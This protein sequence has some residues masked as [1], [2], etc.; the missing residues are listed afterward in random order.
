MA[1]GTR[2]SSTV[3]P[4]AS[5]RGGRLGDPGPHVGVDAVAVELARRCRCAGPRR[6][7]RARRRSDGAGC[8]I[9][10]E[11]IGSWPA[12][13]SSTS[14]GVGD[15]GG[16]RADL[17]EARREGDEPVAGH[18]RRR[19]ASRRRRRTAPPAG[20]SSRRCRSRGRAAAKPAATAAALPPARAA[21]HP[22]GV[23]R[24]AGRAE[25]RVLGRRAHG[26]L[27][28]VRLA[29]DDGAGGAQ[30]LDDGGVVRRPPAV[31]DLRRAG[32]RDAAGAEVVLEGDGHAGQRAGVVAGGDPRGRSRRPRPGPRRPARG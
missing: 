8:G 21:R 19:S 32:R 4:A 29:D 6:R 14:G 16:E 5:E 10:V 20:G 12:I 15:G 9:D 28:E 31:E 25:R 22:V 3:A 17:V 11:S 18:A 24:V 1:A 30:A 13:T 27:V 26:E 23:V 2:A 7:G